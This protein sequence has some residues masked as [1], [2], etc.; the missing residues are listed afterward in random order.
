MSKWLDDQESK[1]E[2]GSPEA[3]YGLA[4]HYY[5]EDDSQSMEEAVK[6]L[7][8]AA[9]QGHADAQYVLG[10]CYCSGKGV[11]VDRTEAIRWWMKAAEQ[12]DAMAQYMLGD[13]FAHGEGVPENYVEAI[14]W[15]EKAAEQ[16]DEQAAKALQR[17]ERAIGYMTNWAQRK[18]R[19]NTS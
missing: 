14:E 12:G 5:S 2:N 13:A 10:T 9:E 4:L 8:K 17:M 15:Y 18:R 19:F 1:A 6:W 7:H 11:P 16:G 3:Q